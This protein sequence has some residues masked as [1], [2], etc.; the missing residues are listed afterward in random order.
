M[1]GL[2]YG[3][4]I[5]TNATIGNESLKAGAAHVV[6][7]AAQHPVEAVAG[8]GCAGGQCEFS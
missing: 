2:N 7:V 8:I 6:E 1:P 4:A 3:R 5:H